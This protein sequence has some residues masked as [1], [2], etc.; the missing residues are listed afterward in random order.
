[1]VIC[2]YITFC[3]KQFAQLAWQPKC[4]YTSLCLEGH[5]D[6]IV[7]SELDFPDYF[8]NMVHPDDLKEVVNPGKNEVMLNCALT[9]TKFF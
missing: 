3:A 4:T 9:I 2:L 6:D 5:R 8:V 1:M 7:L